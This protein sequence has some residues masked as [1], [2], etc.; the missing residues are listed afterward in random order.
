[1]ADDKY[2]RGKHDPEDYVKRQM[3]RH[4]YP[5]EYEVA[6]RFRTDPLLVV[7]QGRYWHDVDPKTGERKAREL[8]VVA[9][10]TG[11]TTIVRFVVECKYLPE[12]W[13]I[14]EHEG[15]ITPGGTE[16][17]IDRLMA[18]NRAKG[19]LRTW[20]GSYPWHLRPSAA[21]KVIDSREQSRKPE[22]HAFEVLRSLTR[23]AWSLHQ[24]DTPATHNAITLPVLVVDGELVTLSYG[25]DAEPITAA[26]DF[27]RV[28]FAGAVLP[29]GETDREEPATIDIVT[30]R[31]L[32]AWFSRAMGSANAIFMEI[33]RRAR[34]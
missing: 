3:A 23:G 5:V 21:F 29:K 20:T 1:M 28:T 24:N 16:A 12:P 22:E 34:G 10:L 18:G 17:A 11:D 9:T 8:D 27:A 33:E 6:R 2:Q 32:G 26:T 7:E 4:G 31:E 19:Q 30:V 13:V 25:P 15:A 14:F